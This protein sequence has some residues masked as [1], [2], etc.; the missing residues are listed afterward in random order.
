MIRSVIRFRFRHEIP[1]FFRTA[2]AEK[3]DE[4]EKEDCEEP[5]HATEKG[6]NYVKNA[7]RVR[8]NPLE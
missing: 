6:K 1:G 5:K 4:K 8:R 7:L 2:G 3:T